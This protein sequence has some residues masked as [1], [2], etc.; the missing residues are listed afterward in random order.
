MHLDPAFVAIRLFAKHTNGVQRRNE[1]GH[2][3]HKA[4][5][6]RAHNAM[7]N[8]PTKRL[9]LFQAILSLYNSQYYRCGDYQ[10]KVRALH[11]LLRTRTP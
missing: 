5:P 6:P 4:V 7:N 1:R 9:Q 8:T 11:A 3:F 2:R 10:A